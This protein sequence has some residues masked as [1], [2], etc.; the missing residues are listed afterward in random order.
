MY[1]WQS[2]VENVHYSY[3][4]FVGLTVNNSRLLAYLDLIFTAVIVLSY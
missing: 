2:Q 3:P 4:L 1:V